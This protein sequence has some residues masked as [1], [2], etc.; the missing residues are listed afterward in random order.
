M[1]LYERIQCAIDYI[2]NKLNDNI[3]I[4]EAAK[5]ACMSRAGFYRLF[6]AFTGYDVKE[7]IRRRRFE[8]ACLD[9]QNGIP[10]VEIALK[11]GFASQEAFI[12]SFKAVVGTTPGNYGKSNF[13]YTF[14]KVNLLEMNF[15]VQ[16]ERLRSKY[17][18]IS[19]LTNLPK[20]RVAS[21]WTFSVSPE[22]DG[23]AVIK[24]WAKKRNLLDPDKGAR[25]FGFDYPAYFAHKRGYEYWITVPGNFQFNENDI[26]KEKIF[27]GG[28]Y[29]LITIEFKKGDFGNFIGKLFGAMDKFAKWCRESE[30]G[31]AFHQYLEE[32]VPEDAES[33]MQRMNCYFPICKNPETKKPLVTDLP[34]FTMA[35]F[36][37][38]NKNFIGSEKAWDLYYKW[39]EISG[40]YQKHKV[41]QVL[42]SVNKM[43]E[44]PTEIWVANPPEGTDLSGLE[45]RKFSGGKYLKFTTLFKSGTS[46]L[47]ENCYKI[48]MHGGYDR[49]DRQLIMEYQGISD[50]LNDRMKHWLYYPLK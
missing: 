27:P 15:E 44:V 39:S 17:P 42:G 2:E 3:Q 41:Y 22:D 19:V 33:D 9:I 50:D 25:I 32:M 18:E 21:Y 12:K 13:N 28:M 26:C 24:E 16:D 31:F 10:A 7:Y 6:N 45:I 29:A 35:V 30:Y 4:P 5:Q 48:Y 43:Y 8:C 34:E 49:A 14:G 38:N 36:H 37:E 20:M 11:Y 47:E 40:D 23:D 1:N 46:E